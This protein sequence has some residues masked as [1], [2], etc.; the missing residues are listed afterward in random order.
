MTSQDGGSVPWHVDPPTMVRYAR[1]ATTAV[2]AASVEAH[3]AACTGCRR[4]AADHADRAALGRVKA[5]LDAHIEAPPERGWVRGLRRAGLGDRDIGLIGGVVALQG[6]WLAA[7]LAVLGFVA[8][9]SQLS[10]SR[11]GLAAFLVLAPL[12]PL[13]GVAAVFG[14]RAD[15]TYELT[16]ASPTPVTRVVLVRTAAVVAMTLPAIVVLSLVLPGWSLLAFAW[17]L[18]ALALCLASLALGTVVPLPRAALGLAVLW[19]GTAAAGLA[20]AGP[21]P[22][23]ST[24]GAGAAAAADLVRDLVAFRPVGQLVLV[25]LSAV[26]AAVLVARASTLEAAQ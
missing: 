23:R 19:L 25:G 11:V 7:S 22:S 2:E 15:P 10:L 17:V 6:S 8:L 14:R 9:A 20:G 1:A 21:S 12:V 26:S 18:P 24:T 13:A 3:L 16:V 4:L 5:Q